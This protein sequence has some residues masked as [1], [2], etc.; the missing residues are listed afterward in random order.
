MDGNKY[1]IFPVEYIIIESHMHYAL[2]L[3]AQLKILTQKCLYSLNVSP[4]WVIPDMVHMQ[5]QHLR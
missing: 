1:K 5:N 3:G 4:P 2:V